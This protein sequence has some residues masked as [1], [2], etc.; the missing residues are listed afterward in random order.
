[1][2]LSNCPLPRLFGSQTPDKEVVSGNQKLSKGPQTVALKLNLSQEKQNG[3]E[4]SAFGFKII[5]LSGIQ[6]QSLP[7]H[8]LPS[9]LWYAHASKLEEFCLNIHTKFQRQTPL[10]H[11]HIL[12]ANGSFKLIVPISS[13]G[14]K[15]AHLPI[16]EVQISYTDHWQALLIKTI[17]SAYGSSSFFLYYKDEFED[18][19]QN[20]PAYLWQYNLEL[21]NWLNS[22]FG[23]SPKIQISQSFMDNDEIPLIKMEEYR[24]VFGH[25]MD[26]VPGLSAIDLLFNLGPDAGEYLR[27]ISL[28]R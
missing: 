28:L 20:K 6:M 10:N 26:F 5:I 21:I 3:K 2:T 9:V 22:Q 15:A 18:L 17:R 24:Q 4:F 14:R 1:M 27:G 23:F 12:T 25:K 16:H 19:V 13:T 8:F 11:C 7:I